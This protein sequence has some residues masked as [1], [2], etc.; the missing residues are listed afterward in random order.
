VKSGRV[1]SQIPELIP[2]AVQAEPVRPLGRPS[3]LS[4][5]RI[6]AGQESRVIGVRAGVTFFD[7]HLA[8]AFQAVGTLDE[9]INTHMLRSDLM[10]SRISQPAVSNV[11]PNII[12]QVTPICSS[13]PMIVV[14]Q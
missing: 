5:P 8:C 1:Q 11:H 3:P 6:D 7:Q 4:S 10:A 13:R 2:P 9:L 14:I 12:A